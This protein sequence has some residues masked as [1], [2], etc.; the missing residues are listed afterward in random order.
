MQQ[1]AI[2]T[3]LNSYLGLLF[4]ADTFANSLEID[5]AQNIGH[6]HDTNW[7]ILSIV[8]PKDSLQYGLNKIHRQ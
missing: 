4:T 2:G 5:Q 1:L 7:L 6:D 8:S 3:L